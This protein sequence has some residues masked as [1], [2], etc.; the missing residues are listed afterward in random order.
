MEHGAR[1]RIED[2]VALYR[3]YPVLF[4]VVVRAD[5]LGNVAASCARPPASD[6]RFGGIVSGVSNARNALREAEDIW[7]GG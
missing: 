5:V 2:P 6:E 3:A 4:C 7:T 1:R